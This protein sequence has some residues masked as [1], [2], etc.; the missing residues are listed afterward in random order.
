[1]AVTER[2]QRMLFGLHKTGFKPGQHMYSL[3]NFTEGLFCMKISIHLAG[4]KTQFN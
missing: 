1:M 4:A 3:E 2:S